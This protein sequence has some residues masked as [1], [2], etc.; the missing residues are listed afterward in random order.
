MMSADMAMDFDQ[1]NDFDD[2]HITAK[3]PLPVIERIVRSDPEGDRITRPLERI[4]DLAESVKD[5]LI[6]RDDSVEAVIASFM[7]RVPVVLFGDPGTAKSLLVRLIADRTADD[8]SSPSFFEYLMTPHTMPEEIFGAVDIKKLVQKEN[9]EFQR[10]TEGM[11]PDRDF[12][13]LDEVFRGGSHILNTLLSIINEGTFHDGAR[14]IEVRALG[15]VGAA[16]DP[17]QGAEMRNLG[18][19]FDRFPV[20]VWVDSI[21]NSRNI[22][23]NEKI[24]TLDKLLHKSLSIDN[25]RPLQISCGN[26]FRI[27]QLFSRQ[28]GVASTQNDGVRQ[29]VKTRFMQL[30]RMAQEDADFALSDRT[31]GQYWKWSRA[32]DMLKESSSRWGE[33]EE[34][35]VKVFTYMGKD[36]ESSHLATDFVSRGFSGNGNDD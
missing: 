26:D 16:N 32:Y 2:L 9:P 19:F 30:F 17:P 23:S 5:Q 12:I 7:S 28:S 1:V 8:S 31:L 36:K 24:S 15:I 21:S 34:H 25:A 11:L 3:M 13:F 18:A 35:F 6:D 10:A 33:S 22:D 4:R 29:A 14:K 27:V 20:R